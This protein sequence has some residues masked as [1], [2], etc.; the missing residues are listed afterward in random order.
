M[1]PRSSSRT[2]GIS[3]VKPFTCRLVDDG[4][5]PRPLRRPVVLPVE[6]GVGHDR[7]RDR[8]GVVLVVALEVGVVAVGHVRQGVAVLVK[9][10]A[11]DRLAYGSIRSLLGL[12]RWP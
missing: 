7:L 9:D 11:L 5:M 6:L 3:L 10:R 12:K 1:S 4:F 2:P 8:P